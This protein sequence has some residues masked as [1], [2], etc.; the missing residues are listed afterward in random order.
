MKKD[1][2][3]NLMEYMDK[4]YKTFNFSEKVFVW[5]GSTYLIVY[6]YTLLKV[7]LGGDKGLL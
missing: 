5:I 3:K 6:A 1:K 2:P 7:F 4:K